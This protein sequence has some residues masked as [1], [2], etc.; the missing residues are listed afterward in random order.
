MDTFNFYQHLGVRDPGSVVFT[1]SYLTPLP[2]DRHSK[3]ADLGCGYGRRATWVARSRCCEM[4]V[5]DTSP[6]RLDATYARAEEGGS[7]SQLVLHHIEEDYTTLPVPEESYDLIMAEGVGFTL[8][9]LDA[10]Q[11]LVPYVK[12]GGHLVVTAPG[13]IDANAPAVVSQPLTERRGAPLLTLEAYYE[14]LMQLPDVKFV[15]QVTLAQ[16]S[17]DEHYQNLGRCLKSLI[18][19][20]ELSP[21]SEVAQAA[22]AE[23]DWYR[24]YARGQ[25]FLQA[26]V[27]SVSA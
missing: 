21:S 11:R 15:H 3:I 6:Q 17:W 13:I 2:L 8:D 23:L 5:F 1:S 26:F 25:I 19:L 27:F 20:G 24:S 4:H 18:K 14:Q 7:E 10:A 16:H 12:R 22:Q 9:G